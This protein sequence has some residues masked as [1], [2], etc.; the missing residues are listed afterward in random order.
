MYV[1]MF[2]QKFYDV[3]K[4]KDD[5]EKI[6]EEHNS[7]LGE[8]RHRQGEEIEEETM[9]PRAELEQEKLLRCDGK[10]INYTYFVY[11]D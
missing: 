9:R 6:V 11:T 2:C 4:Q 7:Q 5:L 10:C 1:V 8:L 3:K